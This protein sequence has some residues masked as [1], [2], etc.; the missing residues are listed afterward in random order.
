[1]DFRQ[2][3]HPVFLFVQSVF[4]NSGARKRL[5]FFPRH[6][7]IRGFGNQFGSFG[8]HPHSRCTQSH[9]SFNGHRVSRVHHQRI[10]VAHFCNARIYQEFHRNYSINALFGGAQNHARAKRFRFPHQKILPAPF[11]FGLDLLH[12]GLDCPKNQNPFPLQKIPHQRRN[13]GR[14]NRHHCSNI[15]YFNVKTVF[16]YCLFVGSVRIISGVLFFQN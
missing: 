12:F 13:R 5:E 2:F 14:R 3:Q 7:H 15:V 8:Q 11:Y 1:M 4:Q 6:C 16:I 9:T 10:Y